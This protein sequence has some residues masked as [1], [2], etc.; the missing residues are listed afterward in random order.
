VQIKF[1]GKEKLTYS[2]SFYF[3]FIEGKTIE[4][5]SSIKQA[6][7]SNYLKASGKDNAS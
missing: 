1:H 4:R 2:V 5:F 6:F 3:T 7:Y